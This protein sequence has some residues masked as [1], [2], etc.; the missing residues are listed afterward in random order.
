MD[1]YTGTI[2]YAVWIGDCQPGAI[3]AFDI[4]GIPVM[5]AISISTI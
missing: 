4:P 3:N 5:L 1:L 2:L